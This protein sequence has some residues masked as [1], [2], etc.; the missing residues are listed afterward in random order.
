[1]RPHRPNRGGYVGSTR[2]VLDGL[3]RLAGA[4]RTLKIIGDG[5]KAYACAVRRHPKR[6]SIELASFPNPKRRKG[7]PRSEQARTRDGAMFPVDLL[8]K[9]LRHTGAHY[10]RETIAFARR[11]NAAMERLFLT[12][13][14]RNFV[15]DQSERKRRRKSPASHLG[16]TEELW[17][18]GRVL[19]KRLFPN[20]QA[21]PELW[22]QFYW[23][24]WQT[25]TLK[26]NAIHKARR[27]Y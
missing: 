17:S 19:T 5:H 22:E 23:R 3:A 27:A 1:L 9:I 6:E 18:W 16:I 12:A 14:W 20:R 8:H 10:R 7:E 11:L 15:K 13:I 4:E 26:S 2:R 24:L 21:L 25:P